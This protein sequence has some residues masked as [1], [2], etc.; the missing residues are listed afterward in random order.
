MSLHPLDL[1]KSISNGCFQLVQAGRFVR[2]C[3]ERRSGT[4]QTHFS[5]NY[6]HFTEVS[7]LQA[8]HTLYSSWDESVGLT[9][10][11]VTPHFY[12]VSRLLL[13]RLHRAV[14]ELQSQKQ[15][16][17]PGDPDGTQDLKGK[18]P[19]LT[20]LAGIFGLDFWSSGALPTSKLAHT[21]QQGW[22][23]LNSSKVIISAVVIPRGLELTLDTVPLV[24]K[25]ESFPWRTNKSL[26]C[27]LRVQSKEK[28]WPGKGYPAG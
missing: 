24:S 6:S 8:L 13:A 9:Q 15:A 25:R 23:C 4:H 17:D 10:H 12:L 11:C 16:G 7:S 18:K 5:S 3:W 27:L 28:K 26:R 22:R 2:S 14:P 20:L 21:I 1:K 19:H